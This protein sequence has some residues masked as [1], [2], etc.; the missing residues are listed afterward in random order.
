MSKIEVDSFEWEEYLLY[1]YGRAAQKYSD[2]AEIES[3]VA[4]SLLVL[5]EKMQRNETVKHPKAYLDAVLKNKYNA[6]LREKY[7]NTISYYD[8]IDM[9]SDEPD[10]EH[11][12]EYEAVRRQIGRLIKIYREVTVRHYIHGQS[13]EQIAEAL[14][15]SAGTVK[16]RL[17]SAR[18]Q[19]KEG[20]EDMEK[21][22]SYSYEPKHVSLG[23]WGNSGLNGEPFSIV[24]EIEGNVLALAYEAPVSVRGL[25]DTMGIACAYLET[26]VERLV[27]GELLGRTAGGLVYTRCFVTCGNEQYENIKEQKRIADEY[28]HI[29]YNSCE[30]YLEK[31][32]ETDSF[33]SMNE[34]QRGTLYLYLFLRA[35]TKTM[36]KC[37]PTHSFGM[38]ILPERKNGGKWYAILKVRNQQEKENETYRCSGPLQV[39][40]S[41]DK[42]HLDC[43]MVDFQSV[44]GDTHWAYP[45]MKYK[46]S[47]ADVLRF[48][49][50]LLDCD[51]KCEFDY[52]GEI[53]GEFEK[54]GIVA[55]DSDGRL[56]LDVPSLSYDELK[57]ISSVVGKMYGT[58]YEIL[59]KP[60]SE[61][62]DR[63]NVNVPKH[64]DGREH[65]VKHGAAGAFAVAQLMSIVEQG[66][67]PYKVEIGKT[68]IILVKYKKR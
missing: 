23:I 10:E 49:A 3:L 48:Y 43:E 41:K 33:L 61:L 19:V 62:Y 58:V 51:V 47:N 36:N 42:A 11:D 59:H 37:D 52:I 39:C 13:V 45:C 26:I 8:C 15:I 20:L 31:I 12:D 6:Y 67:L 9:P 53:A 18:K 17:Y 16:S 46:A 68:P 7:K 55:R 29:L 65:F 54:L 38:D 4:D 21:Y 34:K 5:V 64:V 27:E 14:C 2:C 25:A 32:S 35:I 44:F 40:Y 28:A 57:N 56:R 60:L 63:Y 50:S 24:S 66:L 22:S 1:L 30:P